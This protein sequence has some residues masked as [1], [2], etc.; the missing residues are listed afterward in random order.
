MFTQSLHLAGTLAVLLL[1]VISDERR[2][3]LGAVI[4]SRHSIAAVIIPVH[5]NVTMEIK[6]L[7]HM[8]QFI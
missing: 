2:D 5:H 1:F 8:Y 3:S 7:R 6:L 4:F